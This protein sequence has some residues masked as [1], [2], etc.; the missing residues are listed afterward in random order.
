MQLSWKS[1]T[2]ALLLNVSLISHGQATKTSPSSLPYTR[3]KNLSSPLSGNWHLSGVNSRRGDW[4]PP[5]LS[6]AIEA[7]GEEIHGQGDIVAACQNSSQISGG[8]AYFTG[9]IASD[10][11]FEAN[12]YKD[13]SHV[14]LSIHGTVPAPR[15]TSWQGTYTIKNLSTEPPCILDESGAFTATRYAPFTGTYSGSFTDSRF[16]AALAVTVEVIQGEPGD[17]SGVGFRIPLGGQ[18]TVVGLSCFRSGTATSSRTNETRGDEFWLTFS[19]ED[20]ALLH[21]NGNRFLEDSE[22]S[23]IKNASLIVEG[24]RCSGAGGVSTLTLR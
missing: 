12:N 16:G 10:G 6:F 23:T 19:M 4:R 18:I 17:Y 13:L 14:K 24:G 21:L 3:S 20:G 7:D 8:S 15:D 9:Q 5:F 2:I 22:E 1:A 11:T